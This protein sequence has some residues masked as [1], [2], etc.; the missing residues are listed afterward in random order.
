MRRLLG[1]ECVVSGSVSYGWK[2]GIAKGEV[3]V[4]R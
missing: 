2:I 1:H 3:S 4:S